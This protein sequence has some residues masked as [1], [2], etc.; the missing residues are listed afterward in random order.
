MISSFRY[1]CPHP[2]H[3]IYHCWFQMIIHQILNV[4]SAMGMMLGS[5]M[6]AFEKVYYRLYEMSQQNIQY[7][8]LLFFS[9]LVFPCQVDHCFLVFFMIALLVFTCEYTVDI[10]I[11]VTTGQT[12]QQ[13]QSHWNQG[14]YVE[15]NFGSKSGY[16]FWNQGH[17]LKAILATRQFISWYKTT[18]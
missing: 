1:K 14:R 6:Q 2:L 18:L 13:T 17:V 3:A 7:M 10:H 15:S 16:P 11:T 8:Y 12:S 5:S 4:N 9:M